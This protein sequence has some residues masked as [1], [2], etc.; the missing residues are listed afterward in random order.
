L[1]AAAAPGRS[2]LPAKKTHSFEKWR[3]LQKEI[4][5]GSL[6]GTIAFAKLKLISRMIEKMHRRYKG[7]PSQLT[8]LC[9]AAMSLNLSRTSQTAE[10]EILKT[11]YYSD[12]PANVIWH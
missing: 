1:G 9:R 5:Q 6:S 3:V 7:D 10:V 11:Q 4:A 2:V 8:D 12:F